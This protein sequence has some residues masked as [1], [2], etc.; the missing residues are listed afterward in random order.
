MIS[1]TWI[2]RLPS[3]IRL[4]NSLSWRYRAQ[5]APTEIK[6]L[7]CC[8]VTPSGPAAEPGG[9]E[10]MASTIDRSEKEQTDR[11]ALDHRLV[12][13]PMELVGVSPLAQPTPPECQKQVRHR[14]R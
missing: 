2:G 14:N 3:S 1:L 7:R 13:C 11:K 10:E 9:N 5:S 6:S 12:S 8:G 4:T